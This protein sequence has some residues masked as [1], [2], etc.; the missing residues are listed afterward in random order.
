LRVSH[1]A[2]DRYTERVADIGAEKAEREIMRLLDRPKVR[3]LTDFAAGAS[4]RIAIPA[5]RIILCVS[6]DAVAT[7]LPW[8]WRHGRPP[9]T[10]LPGDGRYAV[11]REDGR[12]PRR[13]FGPRRAPDRGLRRSLDQL[14]R[15]RVDV[16]A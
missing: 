7:V 14:D 13:K 8:Q 15:R 9:S 16:N 6:G 10:P 4:A 12:G 1:H 11:E 3:D 2:V 5:A